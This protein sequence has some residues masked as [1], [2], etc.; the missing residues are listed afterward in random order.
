[1]RLLIALFVISS[2]S[3][4]AADLPISHSRSAPPKVVPLK[5]GAGPAIRAAVVRPSAAPAPPASVVN[6]PGLKQ[7]GRWSKFLDRVFK[8]KEKK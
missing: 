7:Q 5:V 1:M 3:A 2:S 4:L 6:P 8:T